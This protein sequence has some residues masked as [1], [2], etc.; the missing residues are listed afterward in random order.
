MANAFA[1][2]CSTSVRPNIAI[3]IAPQLAT[4]CVFADLY[5]MCVPTLF[6]PLCTFFWSVFEH[7]LNPIE[8]HSIPLIAVYFVFTK[9]HQTLNNVGFK[10][11]L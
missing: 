4:V 10:A 9:K 3:D 7:Q 11:T 1:S 5:P 8:I 2:V 6:P